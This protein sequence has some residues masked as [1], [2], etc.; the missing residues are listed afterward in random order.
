MKKFILLFL[1]FSHLSANAISLRGDCPSYAAEYGN[2]VFFDLN[3]QPILKMVKDDLEESN[4]L[5]NI[6]QTPGN[7]NTVY[8]YY[9]NGNIFSKTPYQNFQKN[10]IQSFFYMNKNSLA[11][12]PFQNNLIHG[13]VQVFYIDGS[14]KMN[15]TYQNGI[16]IGTGYMYY[17]NGNIQLKE[18]YQ[19]GAINGTQY[20]YYPNGETQ[21]V[22]T[23]SNGVLNGPVK[24]YYENG[25][26]LANLIFDNGILT[27]NIC[28]TPLGERSQLNNIAL[29]KLKFGMRPIECFSF[30]EALAY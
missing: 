15:V 1:C 7:N 13:S 6:N 16:K 30:S 3:Q 22:L 27:Q 9:Q 4:L 14:I 28:Y 5:G 23:Y 19:N 26:V 24:L 21:S 11:S 29:Y 8:I 10:G 25:D 18:N 12:I 2:D 20:Q 17:Q